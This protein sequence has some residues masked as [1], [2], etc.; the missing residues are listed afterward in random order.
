M[1]LGTEMELGTNRDVGEEPTNRGGA[2]IL[3]N[4]GEAEALTNT[5]NEVL[6]TDQ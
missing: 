1:V 4:R 3:T 6:N 2:D 5:D